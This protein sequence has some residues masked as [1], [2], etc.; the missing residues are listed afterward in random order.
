MRRC[1]FI[2]FLIVIFAVSTACVLK[3]ESVQFTFDNRTDSFL[4]FLLSEQ[5]AAA[6]ACGQEIERMAT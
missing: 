2:A 4:C 6:G 3:H 1:F 5:G